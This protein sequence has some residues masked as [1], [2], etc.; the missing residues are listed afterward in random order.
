MNNNRQIYLDNAASTKIYPEVLELMSDIQKNCYGNSSSVH[1]MGVMALKL[2]DDAQMQ[3]ADILGCEKNEIIFT[4]GGAE[5]NNLAIKGYSL[6]NSAKG[7]RIISSA[8]EHSTVLKSLEALNILKGYGFTTKLCKIKNGLPDVKHILKMVDEDV[9]LVSIMSVN[10]ETGA[11]TDMGKLSSQIKAKNPNT[12]VHTDAVQ[13]FCKYNLNMGKLKNIDMASISSHKIRGPKGVGAL[14]VRR[15]TQ[16]APLINGSGSQLVTRAGTMDTA[17]IA[18]F[19]MAAQKY[20]KDAI[21]AN[22]KICSLKNHFIQSLYEI[23]PKATVISPEQSSPYILNI[24]IPDIKSEV[25]LNHLSGKNI[26]VSS[27]S[28]CSSKKTTNSHVLEAMGV[29]SKYIDGALRISFCNESTIEEVDMLIKEI[30]DV[31]PI[32]KKFRRK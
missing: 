1:K 14:Y 27:G 3:I 15:G 23:D 13:A 20:N 7:N 10:S 26:Y 9:I 32:L 19:A 6:A 18:G 21:L 22:E 17:G 8:Y 16:I 29:S 25:L 4:S 28:A 5:S 24:A 11:Y 30:I 2:I 12:A 31:L